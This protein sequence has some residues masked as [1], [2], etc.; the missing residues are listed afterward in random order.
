MVEFPPTVKDDYLILVLHIW[1]KCWNTGKMYNLW[2][3]AFN[4]YTV[5]AAITGKLI[6]RTNS[7]HFAHHF[8]AEVEDDVRFLKILF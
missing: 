2:P 1:V 3:T 7:K 4:P 8:G 6:S 5:G